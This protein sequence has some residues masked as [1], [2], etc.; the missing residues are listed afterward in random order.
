MF[1]NNIARNF[2]GEEVVENLHPNYLHVP[3]KFLHIL[4]TFLIWEK[5]KIFDFF[6]TDE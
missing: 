1:H 4:Q 6:K 3:Y 2:E 5:M